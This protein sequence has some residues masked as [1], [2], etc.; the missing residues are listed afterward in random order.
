[1]TDEYVDAVFRQLDIDK[2]NKIQPEELKNY[3]KVFI[4]KLI[5]EYEKALS[6][7]Q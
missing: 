2:D 7:K 4:G 3:A 1:M 5:P 6:T